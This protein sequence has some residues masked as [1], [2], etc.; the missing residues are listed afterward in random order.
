MILD[1]HGK[2]VVGTHDVATLDE[3]ATKTQQETNEVTQ[4]ESEE[5]SQS[6]KEKL[7][8]FSPDNLPTLEGYLIDN[9]IK[10]QILDEK[11]PPDPEKVI[12]ITSQ[13]IKWDDCSTNNYA[14]QP[15][16]F[17]EQCASLK[18]CTYDSANEIL[19]SDV[20]QWL[21]CEEDSK[22][23]QKQAPKGP[24]SFKKTTLKCV[25]NHLKKLHKN[26]T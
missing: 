24:Q 12:E 23:D 3:P 26:V 8:Q 25:H 22:G 15:F 6:V 19:T 17:H 14:R 13:A 7:Q 11:M 20:S 1:E 2:V 9:E 4:E 18:A 16:E 10:Q 21:H 5:T